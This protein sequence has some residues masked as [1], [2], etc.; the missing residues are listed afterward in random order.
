MHLYDHFAESDFLLN[1]SLAD[2]IDI[3]SITHGY[4]KCVRLLPWHWE[5]CTM[6]GCGPVNYSG[7]VE[8]TRQ[9]K[10]AHQ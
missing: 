3:R 5:G 6:T 4:G 10:S 2:D 9:E 8:L 1:D 7:H